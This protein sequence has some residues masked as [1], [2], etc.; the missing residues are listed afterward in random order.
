LAVQQSLFFEQLNLVTTGHLKW[1]VSSVT[2]A[3]DALKRRQVPN[4]VQRP[5]E[6]YKK[7]KEGGHNMKS[8][9]P[10]LLICLLVGTAPACAATCENLASLKLPQ[11]TITAAT[12]VAAGAFV[13]PTGSS[14]AFKSLPPFCRV[15]GVI[16]PSSDSDI[17]F[18]VWLP[19][20]GWNGKYLGVGNGGFAGSISYSFGPSITAPGMA[21]ALAS[22]Y[23]TSSTDTGHKA[24]ATDVDWSLGHPEK[25]IDFGFRAIH[26]TAEKSKAIIHAFYNNDPED[27]YFSSCSNGGRQA[28]MEAQRYPADYNGV[29][30]GD[31]AYFSSHQEAGRIWNMQAFMANPESYIPPSKLPAIEAAVL[32]ACDA[33]DGIKDGI[34]DN[35]TKCH[36]D[37]QKLLCKGA[38]SD[39]C[40]TRP[41]VE[42]LKKIYA[43]PR[44]SKGEQIFP[45]MQPGAETGPAGWGLW[46]TGP[47]P[48]KSLQYAFGIG[49]VAMLVYQ[50]PSWD[51]RSFDFDRDVKLLDEKLG[52]VRNATNPDLKTFKDRGG[53]LILYH[54]WSDP[55]IAPTATVNYYESVISKMGQKDVTNFVRLY[56]VPG[57]QHCGNGPGPNV[58]GTVPT[59]HADPQHSMQAAM[60]RWVREGTAPDAI[61]ATKFKTDGVPASEVVRTRPLCPYPEVAKYKGQG[62][63]DDASNFVCSS[64]PVLRSGIAATH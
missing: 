58:F 34:I 49:S 29:I 13:P 51:F 1:F 22:G 15:Q 18:E 38:E 2:Q 32:T 20:S 54:G 46:I 52:P 10:Q 3:Y 14:D 44:N 41:Q 4:R 57:M 17:E 36:F 31:P 60:E 16:R 39:S 5:W 48:G 64:L 50:N 9:L 45:G 61:I 33:V 26:E 19:L 6:P 28:L 42:A 27:S 7:P 11:T 59:P 25:V 8:F 53:K 56:M 12:T 62:S 63:I 24:R 43:G 47:E 55:A 30:A 21:E 23:A 37:P 35:P 40:L